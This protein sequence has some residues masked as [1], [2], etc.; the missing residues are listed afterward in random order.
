MK[1]DLDAAYRWCRTLTYRHYE[2]F[3]VVSVLVERRLRPYFWALYA[4]ARTVDDLGDEYPGDRLEALDAFEVDLR[5]A[6]AGRATRPLFVALADTVYRCRLPLDPFLALIEAN[7]RD[8]R[9][10]GFSTFDDLLDYCRYSANPVGRLVLALY[11]IRGEPEVGWSDATCTAL[12]I[13]N[14]LQDVGED[15]ARGRCYLPAADL[16]AH[17]V[18]PESVLRREMSGGLAATIRELAERAQALFVR[19]SALEGRVGRRLAWQLRLYRVGGEAILQ[20]VLRPDYNPFVGAP[21]LSR[22]AKAGLALR[23]LVGG[24]AV[25]L[26]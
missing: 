17:G 25:R 18:Q 13:A 16:A 26:W 3:P 14:F 6:F 19:G 24:G 9:G 4:Y 20:S 2:N 5:A 21:R 12:Q 1:N 23:V 22:A 15:A 8:Q 11:D 7:R 10:Q